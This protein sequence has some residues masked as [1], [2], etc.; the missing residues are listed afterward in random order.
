MQISRMHLAAVLRNTPTSTAVPRWDSVPDR[1]GTLNTRGAN[2]HSHTQR[3]T[4]ANLNLN[5][6]SLDM[7]LHSRIAIE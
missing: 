6:T 2:E 4:E 3:H 7:T 1:D 5:R